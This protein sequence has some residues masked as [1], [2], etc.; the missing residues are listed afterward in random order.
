MSPQD[1]LK[2]TERAAGDPR[3]M[4]WHE[5]LTKAGKELQNIKTVRYI[6]HRLLELCLL[7][8]QQE[9]EHQTV[10]DSTTGGSKPLGARG[11]K[12]ADS[13]GASYPG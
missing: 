1:L 10:A 4:E 5:T 12:M 2:E 9:I 13:V 11:A 7:F 6:T 3:L 8:E